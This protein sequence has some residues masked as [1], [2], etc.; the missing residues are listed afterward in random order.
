MPRKGDR[1]SY[2]VIQMLK[3]ILA[4]R[5]HQNKPLRCKIPNQRYNFHHTRPWARCTRLECS[6]PALHGCPC[7]GKLLWLKQGRHRRLPPNQPP[8]PQGQ[9]NVTAFAPKP[10]R[11]FLRLLQPGAHPPP[12]SS[13]SDHLSVTDAF[14][15][16]SAYHGHVTVPAPALKPAG[17][18]IWIE[19]TA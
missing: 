6:S 10:A 19:I 5:R 9:L 2:G 4:I 16:F 14:F 7:S 15:R 3:I 18:H 12:S 11:P 1:G 8:G 17:T 13:P